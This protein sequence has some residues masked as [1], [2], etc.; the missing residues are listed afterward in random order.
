MIQSHVFSRT[1]DTNRPVVHII[2]EGEEPYNHQTYYDD[3]IKPFLVNSIGLTNYE[4]KSIRRDGH[5]AVLT[6]YMV[7]KHDEVKKKFQVNKI[8]NKF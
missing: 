4:L 7:P 6:Y 2:W 8:V 5:G 3:Q 1:Q